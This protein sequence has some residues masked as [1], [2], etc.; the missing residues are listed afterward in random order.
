MSIKVTREQVAAAKIIR[1]LD[2]AEG[3]KS[4]EWILRLINAK[5][6]R[7]DRVHGD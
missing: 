5:E 1:A 6:R 3:R 7:A 4:D 2:K